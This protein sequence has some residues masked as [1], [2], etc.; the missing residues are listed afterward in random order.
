MN[1]YKLLFQILYHLRILIRH[2]YDYYHA[3][4]FDRILYFLCLREQTTIHLEFY[5]WLFISFLIFLKSLIIHYPIKILN[6]FKIIKL[7]F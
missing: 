7:F 5:L 4:Q 2:R 1:Y 6:F 3:A